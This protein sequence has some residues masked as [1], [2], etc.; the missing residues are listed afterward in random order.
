MRFSNLKHKAVDFFSEASFLQEYI[1][2]RL[3][4]SKPWSLYEVNVIDVLRARNLP[5]D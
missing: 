5:L 1:T 2:M 3:N 4:T